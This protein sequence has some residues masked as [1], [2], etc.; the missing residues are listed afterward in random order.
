MGRRESGCL[1]TRAAS[2]DLGG[3]ERGGVQLSKAYF[4]SWLEEEQK[5][6]RQVRV[7][8]TARLDLSLSYLEAAQEDA[9]WVSPWGGW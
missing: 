3:L 9:G 2:L 7:V 6:S 1:E 4:P 5:L 8:R